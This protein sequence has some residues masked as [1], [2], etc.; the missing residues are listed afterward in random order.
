M[1]KFINSFKGR[2]ALFGVVSLLAIILFAVFMP[3]SI[4]SGQFALYGTLVALISGIIYEPV[5]AIV[6]N[7]RVNGPEFIGGSTFG[8][9]FVGVIIVAIALVFGIII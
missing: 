2:A 9:I 4:P 8:S 5:S 7:R 6:E 1:V 3:A